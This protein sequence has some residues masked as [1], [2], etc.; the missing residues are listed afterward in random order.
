MALPEWDNFSKEK[1]TLFY[2]VFKEW[3]SSNTTEI[4]KF[5]E[6]ISQ[7]Q[8][9]KLKSVLENSEIANDLSEMFEKQVFTDVTFR[10]GSQEIKGHKNILSCNLFLIFMKFCLKHFQLPRSFNSLQRHVF[11]R[12]PGE[13]D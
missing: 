12:F 6:N 5:Y 7:N 11:P 13:P 4:A 3:V 10:V 2:E 9:R 8:E 1:S